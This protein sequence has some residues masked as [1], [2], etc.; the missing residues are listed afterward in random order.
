MISALSFGAQVL[1]EPRYAQAAERA[2][3]FILK[4][5]VRKDGRL[6]HRY[7][8]G[9]SGILGQI[10]DYAFFIHGLIDLYQATFEVTYLREAKRLT[11]E[12]LR[13]FWDPA[14]GG[15]FLTG[16]DAEVLLVRQKE[17]YDGA[18]PSGNSVAALD[19]LR[20]GRLTATTEFEEKGSELFSV[21]SGRVEE[22]PSAFSQL[23]VALDF[24][25]G[26]SNE[27]VI[28]GEASDA[29]VAQMLRILYATFMPNKVVLLHPESADQIEALAP[30]LKGQVALS[31]KATAYV[32]QNYACNLPTTD[33]EKL[34][35]LITQ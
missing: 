15:L 35:E 27:I 12:M 2:A 31:G 16:S 17:L 26:P 23:L 13:L 29:E 19:L 30:F 22:S 1:Q 5:L 8:D 3:Q 6:L 33:L 14:Q 4:Q 24:G 20:L 9:D 25:L 32:C 11:R 7:R 28:A 34:K 21:F 18:I 10:E